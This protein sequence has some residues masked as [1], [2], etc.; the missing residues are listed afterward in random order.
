MN[1][2]TSNRLAAV[3]LLIVLLPLSAMAS[4]QDSAKELCKAKIED[5]YGVNNFRNVWSERDGNHKYRVHGQVKFDNHKYDFNCK[6]K[7]G[8][9]K[10]YAYDGPHNQHNDKN[11]D[12]NI[13]T[14]VAVGAGLAIS[15]ALAVAQAS[16]D[17]HSDTRSSLPVSKSVLED[18]CHDMLQ[19]RIRDEHDYTARVSLKDGRIEGHDL[20]GDAKVQYERE[21][22][23]HATYTCHFD[24]RGRLMDS[25]YNLYSAARNA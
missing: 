16:A 22:P 1:R 4:E 2:K 12:N 3:M 13:A 5:V 14:A 20:V 18:E 21:H 25:R 11:D 15:A 17:D 7:H 8:N 19:Y 6:I 10:S 23:H 24:S 9:V